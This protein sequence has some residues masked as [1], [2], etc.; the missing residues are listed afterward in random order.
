M[1]LLLDIIHVMALVVL[2]T[3][4]P[5]IQTAFPSRSFPGNITMNSAVL[6]LSRRRLQAVAHIILYYEAQF[7]RFVLDVHIDHTQCGE[8]EWIKRT[9]FEDFVIYRTSGDWL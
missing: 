2:G 6:P 7:P 8:I 9:T 4:A 5:T 1:R 3:R